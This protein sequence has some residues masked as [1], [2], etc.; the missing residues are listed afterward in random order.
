MVR[1]RSPTT[2]VRS[3]LRETGIYA[4][5]FRSMLERGVALAPGPYEVAFPSMA[6]GPD[7]LTW[8]VDIAGEAITEALARRP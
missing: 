7:E 8:A 5:F 6:H 1:A 3:G 4:P 2:T